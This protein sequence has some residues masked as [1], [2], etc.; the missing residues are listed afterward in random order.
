[1]TTG[2]YVM[3][4]HGSYYHLN[5]SANPVDARHNHPGIGPG[6]AVGPKFVNLYMLDSEGRLWTNNVVYREIL[7]HDD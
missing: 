1:M 4:I 7:H 2:P 6:L 3:K 5:H